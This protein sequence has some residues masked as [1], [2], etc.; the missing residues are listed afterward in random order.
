MN[1]NNLKSMQISNQQHE[2]DPS[3]TASLN[4]RKGLDDSIERL[5]G[6]QQSIN[7]YNDTGSQEGIQLAQ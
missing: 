6:S 1:Q 4:V 3:S 2:V 7:F 5:E